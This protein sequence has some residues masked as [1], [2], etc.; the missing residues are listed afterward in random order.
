MT[1]SCNLKVNIAFIMSVLLELFNDSSCLVTV[2]FTR[3]LLGVLTGQAVKL[4]YRRY[5]LILILY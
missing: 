2:A 4:R 1:V 3:L 5:L